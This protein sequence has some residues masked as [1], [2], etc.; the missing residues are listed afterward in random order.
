MS[1]QISYG[2]LIL[3]CQDKK[4][5]GQGE[6]QGVA[7]LLM[8]HSCS[9]KNKA[10]KKPKNKNRMTTGF[11]KTKDTAGDFALLWQ[12]LK[13]TPNPCRQRQRIQ[14]KNRPKTLLNKDP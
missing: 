14:L 1:L 11:Q 3:F 4:M 6:E 5:Q 2:C 8:Q 10:E 9:R 12:D 13:I 7:Q